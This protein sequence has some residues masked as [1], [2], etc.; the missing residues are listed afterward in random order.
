[1]DPDFNII[2]NASSTCD[3]SGNFTISYEITVTNTGTQAGSV[4]F[5]R[6]VYDSNIAGSI[7]SISAGGTNIGSQIDWPIQSYSGGE[8][9]VYTYTVS[10]PSGTAITDLSSTS[11][12][13]F[14]SGGSLD[15][16]RSASVNRSVVCE[17]TSGGTLPDAGL[18]FEDNNLSF[19]AF[20]LL[21]AVTIYTLQQIRPAKLFRAYV[22]RKDA[23]I[24]H[25]Q[26]NDFEKS[27]HDRVLS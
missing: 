6:E 23:K 2:T 11:I 4:D 24:L 21:L 14:D 3:Q 10:L 26:R 12:V 5:V 27:V 7:T 20:F 13:Q 8:S 15:N 18:I 22:A 19:A 16:S 25:S 17:T 9:R 1:M